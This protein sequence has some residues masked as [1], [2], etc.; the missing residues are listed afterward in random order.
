MKREYPILFGL[1]LWLCFT[2]FTWAEDSRHALLVGCTEYPNHPHIRALYG[3]ANDVPLWAT[4]LTDPKGFAFPAENV[5]TLVGWPDDVKKRPSYANIV[6]GFQSLIEKC[7]PGSRVVIVLSGH[8]LQVPIPESQT[9]PMDPKNPEPD[10]LDEVFLPADVKQFNETGLENS[11][12]DDQVGAWLTQLKDKGAHV[13]IVFDCCH[14]GTMT[15]SAPGPSRDV[16]EISRVA[17]PALLG[18]PQEKIEAAARRGAKAVAKAKRENKDITDATIPTRPA[19]K[20]TPGSIVAFYAAQPFEET[21]ELPMPD[22][23]PIARENYYGL[24]SYT[25]LELLQQRKSPVTYRGLS[26]LLAV[27]Y[28]STR[29]TRSP[30]PFAE[31]DLDRE[32]LGL[33]RWPEQST[34]IL[35]K[36]NRMLQLNGGQL[37]G[38]T[39]GTVL[40]VHPPEGDRRDRKEILGY[41]QVESVTPTSARVAPCAYEN[42]PEVNADELPELSRCDVVNHN[43]GNLR[44]QLYLDSVPALQSAYENL[45]AEVKG[46]VSLQEQPL[47]AEWV[48][49]AGKRAKEEFGISTTQEDRIYL[50]QGPGRVRS[51]TEQNQLQ[52]R[53]KQEGR[54]QTRKVYGSYSLE[55]TKLAGELDRDL[56][57][58]FKW[59]NLWKIASGVQMMHD[60]KTHGFVFEVAKLKNQNDRSGG[61]LLRDGLLNDGQEMEFRFRNEGVQ[62]LWVAVL[63]LDSNLGIEVYWSGAI[64]RGKALKPIR[65]QMS[66]DGDSF[67]VEGMA[68]FA[69]PIAVQKV[70]PDYRFLEQQPLRVAEARQRSANQAA[71]TPFGKLMAAG[72]FNVG[73][74]GMRKHVETTPAILL[75]PWVLVP[76]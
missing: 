7:G 5:T 28:R 31:G 3:P 39:E 59:Q 44:I 22:D 50:I 30:T 15:R 24:L 62:D 10:G 43:F 41:L 21:P 64:A 38:L 12:R 33:N 32:V 42:Q 8:G 29:G 13:W 67:G 69:V 9:D 14:S 56:P 19:S 35:Q 72:A 37:R 46:M 52:E 49:V 75:Q 70:E 40:S 76:K 51:V 60:G 23:A 54:P 4:T 55:E 57:K 25:V 47:D 65:T 11:L 61:E 58:I 71:K 1:L 34:L 6:Q 20:E 48:L 63:Y 27:K 18:I 73:T 74:R 68:V 45:H 36:P 17:D 26:R 16:I 2:N 53:L 66:V